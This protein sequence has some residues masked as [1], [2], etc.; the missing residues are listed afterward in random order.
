M[1]FKSACKSG[2][3]RR[4][5]QKTNFSFEK[6]RWNLKLSSSLL[7]V[8]WFVSLFSHCTVSTTL[9]GTAPC[10]HGTYN[11]MYFFKFLTLPK[12]TF[13]IF[14]HLP[15][16][17]YMAEGLWTANHHTRT[18]LLIFLRVGTPLYNCTQC[19][20]MLELY[21]SPSLELRGL[22]QTFSILAVSLCIKRGP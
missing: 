22:A 1:T 8:L 13:V 3:S 18:V 2:R 5:V 19:L 6:Q 11:S 15:V 16:M 4:L 21:N 7:F 9:F 20:C 17:H 10:K 14:L 12:L